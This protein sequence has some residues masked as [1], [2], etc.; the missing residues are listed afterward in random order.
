MYQRSLCPL[1]HEG[2]PVVKEI[3]NGPGTLFRADPLQGLDHGHLKRVVARAPRA[4]G[5]SPSCWTHRQKM[6]NTLIACLDEGIHAAEH[7]RWARVVETLRDERQRPLWYVASHEDREGKARLKLHRRS[8]II[9]TRTQLRDDRAIADDSEEPAGF[10][11]ALDAHRCLVHTRRSSLRQSCRKSRDRRA[12]ESQECVGGGRPIA[13][14]FQAP[15]D[16]GDGS[17][18]LET[19]ERSH[20]LARSFV[21]QGVQQRLNGPT[22]ANPPELLGGAIPNGLLRQAQDWIKSPDIVQCQDL[23]QRAHRL[24]SSNCAKSFRCE[25]SRF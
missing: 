17:F 4:R 16:V 3:L 15:H 21:R 7:D 18:L 9:K 10:G 22:V 19:G 12:S 11:S 13:G 24:L 2:A 20:G 23:D 5:R 1:A 14:V 8:G 6:R 25:A